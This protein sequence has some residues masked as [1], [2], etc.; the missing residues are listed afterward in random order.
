MGSWLECRV[1]TTC[2]ARLVWRED[3]AM[4]INEGFGWVCILVGFLAGAGL[5]LKFYQPDFGGVGQA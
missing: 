1:S 2:V 3:E 5:G 4:L